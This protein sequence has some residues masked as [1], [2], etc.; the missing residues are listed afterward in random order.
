MKARMRS[1]Y[2]AGSNS[3]SASLALLAQNAAFLKADQVVDNCRE[4]QLE[5]QPEATDI[6]CK[7][8]PLPA[9]LIDTC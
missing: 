2:A 9:F 8:N 6:Q 7:R 1:P 5:G 3:Q 4:C